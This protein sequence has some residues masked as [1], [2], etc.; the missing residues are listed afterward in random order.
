MG[1]V[2]GFISI[3]GGVGKT[4]VSSSLAADLANRYGKKVLLID[5]NYSAPNLGLHMDVVSPKE[6]IHHVLDGRAKLKDAIHERHGVD[7]VPG[8]YHY[9]KPLNYFKLRDKINHAKKKYDFVVIDSSP[10]LNE[11][12]LS[13]MLASDKLFVITTPDYPT[14]SCSLSAARLAKK[15]GKPIAGM[16]VNKIRDPKY[17]LTL[18]DIEETLEI[19]VVA[20]IPDDKRSVRALFHRKPMS[21]YSKYGTFSRSLGKLTKVISG[22]NEK[23]GLW[24]KFLG[25][26]NKEEVNRQVLQREFYTGTLKGPKADKNE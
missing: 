13:T 10:S 3:K 26:L 16:I 17:E 22:S 7:V 9:D 5:A 6:T 24:S 12:L 18:K 15:R 25:N 23:V 20:R 8:A 1:K 4:T 11:E 14:L 21:L 19:P 2:L